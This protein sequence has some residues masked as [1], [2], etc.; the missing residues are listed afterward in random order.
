M[1]AGKNQYVKF[2]TLF[3]FAVGFCRDLTYDLQQA[4][5]RR[6]SSLEGGGGGVDDENSAAEQSTWR[7]FQPCSLHM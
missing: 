6:F 4:S 5:Q 7:Y 3:A 1:I 2:N